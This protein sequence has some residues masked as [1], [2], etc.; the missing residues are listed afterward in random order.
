MM[1]GMNSKTMIV[2]IVIVN[3]MPHT[4]GKRIYFYISYFNPHY[5]F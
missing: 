3:V 2:D 4:K 5:I 1:I